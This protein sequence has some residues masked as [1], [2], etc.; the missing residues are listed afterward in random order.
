MKST[1]RVLWILIREYV[2][3]IGIHNAALYRNAL[4]A[5]STVQTLGLTI[6]DLRRDESYSVASLTEA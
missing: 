2:M 3:A 6:P 4:A 5:A 1:C